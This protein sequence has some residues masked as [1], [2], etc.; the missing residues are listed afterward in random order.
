M[1]FSSMTPSGVGPTPRARQP[2][3]AVISAS[4][5]MTLR[6]VLK[7]GF[8]VHP[9]AEPRVMQDSQGCLSCVFGTDCSGVW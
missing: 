5:P 2:P 9:Q 3:F 1:A 8:G 7:P 6:A 4:V